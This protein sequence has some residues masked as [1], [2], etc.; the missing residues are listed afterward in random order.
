MEARMELSLA[1]LVFLVLL[2]I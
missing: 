2:A 1:I